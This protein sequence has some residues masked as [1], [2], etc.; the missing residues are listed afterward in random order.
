MSAVSSSK[1]S[2]SSSNTTESAAAAVPAE[3]LDQDRLSPRSVAALA[4]RESTPLEPNAGTGAPSIEITP[5]P[6]DSNIFSD[7]PKVDATIINP[8]RFAAVA[9]EVTGI[10]QEYNFEIGQLV[11]KGSVILEISKKRYELAA[12]KAGDNLRGLRL[13]LKRA[14]KEKEIRER[15]VS[16]DAS[17]VQDL[18]KA[19]A[20]EEILEQKVREA[21]VILKQTQLDLEACQVKAP[22]TG[23]I[24]VRYKEPFEAAGPLEKLFSLIDSSKVYAVAYVPENLMQFFQKGSKAAFNDSYGRQFVGEVDKIEPTIDPKTGSQKVFVLMDNAQERLG[25]GMTGSLESIK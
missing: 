20:E 23:Y 25:I 5:I 16:L 15:L 1:L 3:A 10:I 4:S 13:A 17:T 12:E 9:T 6:S 19:E 24:A 14:Q 8:F 18:L 21:E 2:V 11:Q 22:F 7:A